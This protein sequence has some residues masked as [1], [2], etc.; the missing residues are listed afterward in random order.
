MAAQKALR[1]AFPLP[2]WMHFKNI[3]D[4]GEVSQKC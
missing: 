1:Q 2:I 3:Q 4:V